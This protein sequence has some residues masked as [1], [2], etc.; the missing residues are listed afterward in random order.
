MRRHGSTFVLTGHGF[1]SGRAG[2]VEG[3]RALIEGALAFGDVVF[4]TAEQTAREALSHKG[5]AR[6]SHRPVDIDPAVF[7]VF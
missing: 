2:R 3:L 6:R 7:P 1:L 4:K 5:T